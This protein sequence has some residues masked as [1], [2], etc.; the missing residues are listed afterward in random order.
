[1]GSTRSE[2]KPL[3][4]SPRPFSIL[5]CL[6]AAGLV[7]A[8]ATV[9]R[10]RLGDVQT[11][12]LPIE[13]VLEERATPVLSFSGKTGFLSSVT[14]GSVLSFNLRSGKILGSVSVGQ[15]AGPV[16]MI[17][18]A[19]RRLLAVPAVNDPD[20]GSPAAVSI[21]DATN[22]KSFNTVATVA[23][24]PTAHLTPT[25]RVLLTSNASTGVVAS[26][27]D[28]PTVYS[29]SVETGQIVSQQVVVGR[30]SEIAI[31]DPG[32]GV[33]G[34]LVAVTSAAA[35]LVT[36]LRLREEGTFE[37][38]SAFSPGD[39]GVEDSNNPVFSGD[40]RLL[41]LAAARDE[42]LFAFDVQTGKLVSSVDIA[43]APQRISVATNQNGS[44]TVAVVRT[45]RS[46]SEALG[47]VTLVTSRGGRLDIKAEF[48]PPPD[49][50]QFSRANNPI[51]VPD[52]SVAFVPS[53]SGVL[54]AFSTETGEME[55]NQ[56]I[57]SELLGIALHEKTKTV[58]VVRRG[59]Q[60]DEIVLVPFETTTEN[61]EATAAP[62]ISL[63]KPDQAEQG[64]RKDLPL[65]VKGQN[66]ATGAVLLVNDTAVAST[67]VHGGT[68][69]AT[70]PKGLFAQAGRLPIRVKVGDL[71]STPAFIEVRNS[72]GAVIDR[73]DPNEVPGP[74][75][76]IP[77]RVIG[78]NFRPTSLISVKAGSTG[79]REL[80]TEYVGPTELRGVI[81]K[82]LGRVIGD[83]T[84]Q[85]KNTDSV[86]N[87]RQLSVFGPRIKTLETSVGEVVAGS[88]AFRLWISGTN[89]RD[90]AQV[91]F[92]G[93][94]VI[95][96]RARQLSSKLI[97]VVVREREAQQSAK[98][99]V[100]VRN[101]EGNASEPKLFELH[102]P[103]IEAVDPSPVIAGTPDVALDIR[104][105]FFR[106]HSSVV[107]TDSTGHTI[108]LN[109]T[110]VRFRST[111]RVTIVL[112]RE[113]NA[114]VEQPG[115][116][117]VRVINPNLT[118][119]IPSEAAKITVSGPQITSAI[120][121]SFPDDPS[122]MRLVITG[123]SFRNR[124]EV[125]FL[126]GGMAFARI[127]P[128]V[129]DD[130]DSPPRRRPVKAASGRLVVVIT[131]A[132]LE[133]WGWAHGQ[134]DLQVLVVN[135]G[136][137]KSNALKP[138]ESTP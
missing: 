87:E 76:K 107:L 63:L 21:I 86:S 61:E 135:P 77:F 51:I 49:Q 26:S 33:S 109:R 84:V 122:L 68:L 130:D 110:R 3:K 125:E 99:A 105:S 97:R 2:V 31:Y 115:D 13:M 79:A 44:E 106:R 121:S 96:G 41:Y 95:A 102:A 88:G 137:V 53:S 37:F 32:P 136:E 128:E 126:R 72:A 43:P 85:V 35:N 132:K 56:M 16:S 75:G 138:T 27:F 34:R 59:T 70:L 119:G 45:R 48:T 80:T 67:L 6:L 22:V 38:V 108:E 69:T 11:F 71:T 17:E 114:L 12:K 50:I 23:L 64:R 55:T 19:E 113:L 123:S 94:P 89:F 120:I 39:R 42:R 81:P 58:A 127:T 14:G 98:I 28:E 20:Q 46:N 1:M 25:T 116:L 57:G 9:T 73:L 101:P 40:G 62:V 18:T 133:R 8:Q 124:A 131:A 60:G 93:T 52:L 90:G 91:E 10:T 104:G 15:G 134:G 7:M 112:K 111:Q 30:P 47:G 66:F 29:F 78:N 82:D 74:A 100:V 24:P 83:I 65:I 54:F 103:E 117:S 5:G 4:Q 36:I 92:D 129:S 118:T